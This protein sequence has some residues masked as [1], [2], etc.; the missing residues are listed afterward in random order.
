MPIDRRLY[1]ADWDAIRE[2]IRLRAGNR[3]ERCGAE[4]DKPHPRS[5]KRVV[6]TTAHIGPTRHDKMDCRDEVMLCLCQPCHL[7]EDL[8]DHVRHAAETRRRRKIEAGQLV[9]A[10]S[11]A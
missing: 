7:A 1:P 5:G 6:L 2:R 9:L 3:C 8:D 11:F 4:N 10:E